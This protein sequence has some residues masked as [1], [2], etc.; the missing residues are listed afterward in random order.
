[1]PTLSFGGGGGDRATKRVSWNRS[2][3]TRGRI[4][5]AVA[6]CVDNQPQQ[7]QARRKGKPPVPKCS[8]PILRK[9]SS[10][11]KRSMASSCWKR[12]HLPKA[13]VHG[14]LAMKLMQLLYH[15]CHQD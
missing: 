7:K 11:L 15:I 6:A 10:T 12:A 4:S 13:L 5:I 1:M 14:P 2:L 9:K 3:S 8:L